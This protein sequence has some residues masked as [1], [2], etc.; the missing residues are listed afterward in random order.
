MNSERLREVSDEAA[1]AAAATLATGA[2]L[3]IGGPT[4]ALAGAAAAPMLAHA[5]TA[6][7]GHLRRNR[8]QRIS[9]TIAHVA[10]LLKVDEAELAR[11]LTSDERLLELTSRVIQAAQ[12]ASSTP[13][14]AALSRALAMA[15]TDPS[16]ATLD[17]CELLHAAIIQIDPPHMRFMHAIED[18]E[19]LPIPADLAPDHQCYGMSLEQVFKRDPGLT[20]GGHAILQKLLS[21]GLIESCARGISSMADRDKPYALSDLGR[22]LLALLRED[23]EP[24]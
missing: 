21:L 2:G 6:L 14:R 24:A 18:A 13:K 20:P 23:A 10:F 5:I 22:E 7:A 15:A 1:E 4:G 19:P 3:A 16:P 8:S 11:N 17:V 12:D 9:D